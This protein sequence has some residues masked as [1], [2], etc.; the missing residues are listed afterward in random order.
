M[1]TIR[2]VH[3]VTEEGCPC[4]ARLRD[5]NPQIRV[6]FKY[7]RGD[8]HRNEPLSTVRRLNVVEDA[9]ARVLDS[10]RRQIGTDVNPQH[11]VCL[12]CS[13]PEL[14]PFWAVPVLSVSG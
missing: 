3:P 14:V 13:R 7:S 8:H 5:K 9:T 2:L 1:L 12:L 4:R 6:A 10:H 11:N